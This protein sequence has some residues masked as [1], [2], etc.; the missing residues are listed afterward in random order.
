[1]SD[2]S[3]LY[4]EYDQLRDSTNPQRR[5]YDLEWDAL[6]VRAT[7]DWKDES[8]HETVRDHAQ[9]SRQTQSRGA[10]RPRRHRPDLRFT[11]SPCRSAMS[12]FSYHQSMSTFGDPL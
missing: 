3:H 2:S 7:A 12:T 8:D 9:R 11:M 10:A 6:V 1:M 5:G 4:P